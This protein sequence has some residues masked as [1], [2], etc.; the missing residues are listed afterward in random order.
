MDKSMWHACKVNRLNSSNWVPT[1]CM[2][3]QAM[4]MA[5]LNMFMAQKTMRMAAKP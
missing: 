1:M 2:A 4:N 5:L 3:G